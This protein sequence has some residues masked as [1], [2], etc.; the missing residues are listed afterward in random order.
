MSNTKYLQ[1]AVRKYR[2][3]IAKWRGVGTAVWAAPGRSLTRQPLPGRA[4]APQPAL[5]EPEHT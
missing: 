5:V 3:N 2:A 1:D 4:G